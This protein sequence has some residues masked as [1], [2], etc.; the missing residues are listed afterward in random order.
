MLETEP[1]VDVL[2]TDHAMPVMSGTISGKMLP[3][4]GVHAV[5]R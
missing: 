4:P 5:Y 1:A 2:M 3:C